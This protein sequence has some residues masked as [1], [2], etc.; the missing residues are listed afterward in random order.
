MPAMRY[1]YLRNMETNKKPIKRSDELAPL[2]REHH[3]GLLFIWKIR[4][5]LANDTALSTIAGYCDWY[6]QKSLSGHFRDEEELLAPQAPAGD[7]K[8]ERMKMEH[9]EIGEKLSSIKEKVEREDLINLANLMEAHIRYEERELFPYLEGI[10]TK[11]QLQKVHQGLNEIP[12]FS[13]EWPEPFWTTKRVSPK[14]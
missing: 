5:G 2:S 8:V 4:Q 14:K 3:D 1:Y 9:K 13:E 11:E 10:L 7:P 12:D 6:W